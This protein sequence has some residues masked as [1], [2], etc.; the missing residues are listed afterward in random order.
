[1]TGLPSELVSWKRT[2][3]VLAGNSS[4]DKLT[5][6]LGK[7]SPAVKTVS[8]LLSITSDMST[9]EPKSTWILHTEKTGKDNWLSQNLSEPW[10]LWVKKDKCLSSA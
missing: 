5:V 10:S 3:L 1:M 7:T 8:S 2:L 6:R 4:Q 9:P